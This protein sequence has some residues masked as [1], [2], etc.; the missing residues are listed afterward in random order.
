MRFCKGLDQ[1][2]DFLLVH[3]PNAEKTP[4]LR[5]RRCGEEHTYDQCDKEVKPKCCICGGEHSAAHCSCEV[6]LRA[7]ER[8]KIRVTQSIFRSCKEGP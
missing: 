8:Q 6:G 4:D 1:G 2:V 5:Y 7:G 3:T